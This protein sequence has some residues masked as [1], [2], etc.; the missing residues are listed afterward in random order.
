VGLQKVV[1]P[2]YCLLQPNTVVNGV[3]VCETTAPIIPIPTPA[4]TV[5]P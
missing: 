4:G 1:E 5:A 3:N 2:Y